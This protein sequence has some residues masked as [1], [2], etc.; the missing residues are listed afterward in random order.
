MISTQL[1]HT[2]LGDMLAGFSEKGLCFLEF[3]D[4]EPV[5]AMILRFQKRFSEIVILNKTEAS[6]N[7]ETELNL[8]F[9]RKLID[10]KVNI[11]LRGTEF[12]TQVWESLRQIPYGK[13]WT[14]A[15]QAEYL[16]N[17]KAIRASASAN[18]KN[19]I[20]I[21]VPCHRVI[22]K[23]GS[24]TGYAGGLHRKAFLLNLESN[25][26]LFSEI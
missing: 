3:L 19:P 16:G 10:F 18:G 6:Q 4:N 8:Y 2:P 25:S 23:N 1:Y 5:E 15:Q 7:L 11:D 9:E 24:L 21:V 14:Y 12:Q 17:L 20:A 22:G 26:A 13:T